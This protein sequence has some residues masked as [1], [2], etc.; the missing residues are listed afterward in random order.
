MGKFLI[1]G[2][3][4]SIIAQVNQKDLKH[5]EAGDISQNLI[6]LKAQLIYP[7]TAVIEAVTFTQRVLNSSAAAFEIAVEF[8]NSV[9]LVDVDKR[10]YSHAVDKYFDLKA[11]KKDT[12]FDCVVASVAD[13]YSADAI[14]SFDKFYKKHGFKLVSEWL[15]DLIGD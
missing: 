1:V 2:D 6:E 13:K 8:A 7:V 9:Q 14:F 10:I 5:K 4:D 12:M 11:R 3:A 15:D